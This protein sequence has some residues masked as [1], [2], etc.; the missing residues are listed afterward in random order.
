MASIQENSAAGRHHGEATTHSRA[1][2]VVNTFTCAAT[3]RPEVQHQAAG[4]FDELAAAGTSPRSTVLM[5]RR[6]S[7]MADQRDLA[8]QPRLTDQRRQL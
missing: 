2:T 1:C 5:R 8:G 3:P 7:R 6:S 4:V